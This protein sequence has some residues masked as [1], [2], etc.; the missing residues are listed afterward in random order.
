MKTN[1]K[2]KKLIILLMA[3]IFTLGVAGLSFSA[4][5]VKGTVS[6]IEGDKL[7]ILDDKGKEKTVK[8]KDLESLKEIKVG[9]WVLV[10]DGKVT[11]EKT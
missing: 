9:D 6:K 2:T 4:Q 10:K 11:K 1:M 7:T 5:E 8:V 3:A